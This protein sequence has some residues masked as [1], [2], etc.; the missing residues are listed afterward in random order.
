MNNA[1]NIL[2]EIKHT[3]TAASRIHDA[4]VSVVKAL[5]LVET[6]SVKAKRSVIPLTPISAAGHAVN[7]GSSS[8]SYPFNTFQK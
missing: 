5:F 4:V 1:F 7:S 2:R 3:A 6:Y 8:R